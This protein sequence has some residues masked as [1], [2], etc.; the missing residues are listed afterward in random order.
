MAETAVTYSP[1]D[2]YLEDAEALNSP[3]HSNGAPDWLLTA[4]EQAREAFITQE[5]PHTKMEEWRQTN[6]ASINRTP[7][8]S[9]I[10]PTGIVPSRKSLAPFLYE[11]WNT[12]VFVDGHYTPDLSRTAQLTEGLSA[13]SLRDAIHDPESAAAVKQHL[14]QVLQD[15]SA[16]TTLNTAFLQDGGYVHVRKNAAIEAPIHLVFV[17]SG[18]QDT[19]AAYA[20]N[21][22]VLEQSSE[23]T[24]VSSYVNLNEKHDERQYFNNIVDE[25]VLGDN[26][27][28][29]WYKVVEEGAHSHHLATTEVQQAR[30]SRFTSYVMSLE[31]QT[32]RNQLCVALNG[33]GA[34]C[35]LSGLYL[36]DSD[37]LIDNAIDITHAKPHC[38]SRIMYKGVLDGKSKAVFTGK[39]HV[40]QIAQKTDSDQLS[41]NLV[42]SD[43]ATIHTRPQLE[44]YADDVKCTHGATIG[45]PPEPIIFYF[46]SRGIDEPTARAMLT[47][48][49]AE[50]VISDIDIPVLSERLGRYVYDKF[51]P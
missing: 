47:Y 43:N 26:A 33:E 37:R 14:N 10:N 17:T 28:L 15:R 34:S 12:L 29:D 50:E 30:D 36:N 13:G 31:G 35:S 48:G 27:Q 49:F 21:L 16:Y 19:T 9:I 51:S 45:S 42:L 22:I 6:I 18:R 1:K 23:A 46:K 40:Y 4:R 2:C 44:I 32:I 20:R 8:R 38:N 3:V 7:F 39:V 25:V 5:F 24:I 11:D 41:N